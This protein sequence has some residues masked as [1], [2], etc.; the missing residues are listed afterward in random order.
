MSLVQ[1]L[2]RDGDDKGA[3][4][5]SGGDFQEDFVNMINPARNWDDAVWKLSLEG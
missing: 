2:P 5:K 4:E 1:S 3:F